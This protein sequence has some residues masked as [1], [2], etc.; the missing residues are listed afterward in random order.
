[1]IG[2]IVQRLAS[3]ATTLVGAAVVVFGIMQLGG[4]PAAVLLPADA[5]T[6]DMTRFRHEHGLDQSIFVQFVSFMTSALRGD[7]GNSLHFG[8]PALPIALS[9]LPASAELAFAALLIAVGLA[10][11]AGV[12]A[13]TQRGRVW[14]FG[15]RFAALLGQSVPAYWLGLVLIL[16]LGV[17]LRWL[18]VGGT[19]DISHLVLPAIALSAM[20]FAR[21]LR[22]TRVTM[23]DNLHSEYLRTAVAKGA[24]PFRVIVGHALRNAWLPIVTAIGV[25]IA[26][27]ISQAAIVET[28]FAWPG[29]GRLAVQAVYDRDY[30]LV[31]V[32]VLLAATAFVVSNAAI[33]IACAALD[34]RLRYE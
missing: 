25:D 23:L 2:L 13:A 17:R 26:A 28:V 7:F 19:G 16:L 22:L 32:I 3:A 27:L 18:P 9:R 31:E 24:G 15:I 10:V 11:P 4:D 20:P 14:D 6:A 5:T 33:D 34:P 1:M 8:E 21:L 30:P 29:L 12:V